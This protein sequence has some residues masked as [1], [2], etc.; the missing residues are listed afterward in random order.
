M[1][2]EVALGKPY[3]ENCDVYSFCILFWQMLQLDTP[4]E[5]YSMNMFNTRVVQGGVRPK[6]DP[7][8]P[9]RI[10]EMLTRG[11]GDHHKR[12]SMSD[13][14]ESLREELQAHTDEF[15]EGASGELL[16]ASR[17]SELSLRG[18]MGKSAKSLRGL[19]EAERQNK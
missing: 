8:W 1:A 9:Q 5:G 13:V 12:Q 19:R 10:T 4:F 7:K 16:D 14:S 18:N 2:P 3:N 15:E 17:K 6:C 11:W